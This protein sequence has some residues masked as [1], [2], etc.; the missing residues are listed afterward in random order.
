MLRAVSVY[1]APAVIG[2]TVS[3]TVLPQVAP[4]TVTPPERLYFEA[5]AAPTL[6]RLSEK[7]T[8]TV[9]RSSADADVIV[10]PSGK[11]NSYADFGAIGFFYSD[12][13][14]TSDSEVIAALA[15]FPPPP[16][17]GQ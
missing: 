15:R 14:Q 16:A 17:V 13:R 2:E 10:G 6:S 7:T 5:T 12:F 1:D 3:V 4:V 11:V 9:T 8:C